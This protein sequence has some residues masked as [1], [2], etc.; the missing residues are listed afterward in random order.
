IFGVRK[1][2]LMPLTNS[3]KSVSLLALSI[4]LAG[5]AAAA[6]PDRVTRPVDIAQVTALRGNLAPLA[7]P[8]FGRGSVDPVMPMNYMILVA[9]PSA[10]Q[11]ADLDQLLA[12]QQ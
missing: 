6:V 1:T 12:N 5:V 7:Q 3:N 8:Q 2:F 11:Q 9:Q 10:A 4:G